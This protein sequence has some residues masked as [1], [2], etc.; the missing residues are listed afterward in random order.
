MV[1][2]MFHLITA[3]ENMYSF[4]LYVG[5]LNIMS[6]KFKKKM[7]VGKKPATSRAVKPRVN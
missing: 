3:M 7:S 1:K 6:S 4:Y 2:T 5:S